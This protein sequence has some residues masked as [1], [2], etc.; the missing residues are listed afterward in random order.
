[1]SAKSTATVS[2][3]S[4]AT[5]LGLHLLNYGVPIPTTPAFFNSEQGLAF[6]GT[7]SGI[8]ATAIAGGVGSGELDK[9]VSALPSSYDRKLAR[10]MIASS[11]VNVK[12][13]TQSGVGVM[14]MIFTGRSQ[15][16]LMSWASYQFVPSLFV[17]GAIAGLLPY[18]MPD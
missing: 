12:M 9:T 14:Y 6:A 15:A 2:M 16:E 17:H 4:I 1:M 3:L 13:L 8:S 10:T 18:M 11:V 5:D 7:V